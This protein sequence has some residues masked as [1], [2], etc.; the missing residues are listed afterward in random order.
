[1]PLM[2]STKGVRFSPMTFGWLVISQ[3]DLIYNS[4]K[5][6]TKLGW[7]LVGNSLGPE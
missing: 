1:M 6:S 7:V 3:Q 2:T 5:I 4:E